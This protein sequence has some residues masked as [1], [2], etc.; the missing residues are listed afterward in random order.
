MTPV[1]TTLKSGR[2]PSFP[3]WMRWPVIIGRIAVGTVFIVSGLLKALDTQSFMATLPAYHI[4]DWLLPPGALVPT[5]EV[6]LGVALILGIALRFI[7]AAAIAMLLFFSALLIAGILGGELDTCGCFGS[8][9]EQSPGS[10]LARNVILMLICGIVWHY[11]REVAVKWKP[12]KV[13]VVGTIILIVGTLTGFTIHAPQLDPTLAQVG[14]FFPSEGITNEEMLDMTGTQLVFVFT[15][16]CEECWNEVANAKSLAADSSYALIGVTASDPS[17]IEWFRQEFDVNF[18][19]YTYDPA[20]F[21]EAFHTWPALYYLQDGLIIGK[22]EDEVPA[23]KTLK[24]VL[25]PEW[26]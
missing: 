24:E 11:Y 3:A 7:A 22:T 21:G 25:L 6:A 23:P 17:E 1:H 14:E 26:F 20:T 18:P 5:L 8:L 2:I 12:Y 16:S 4:P 19:I 9:L 13:G 15:V 10:A